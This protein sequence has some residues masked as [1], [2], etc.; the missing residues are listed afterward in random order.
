MVFEHK[1]DHSSQWPTIQSVAQ[2]IGCTPETPHKWVREKDVGLRAGT[3]S[4]DRTRLK[5]LE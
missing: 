5:E 3:T 1:H 2:K 4:D